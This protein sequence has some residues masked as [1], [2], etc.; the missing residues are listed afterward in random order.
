MSQTSLVK[1]ISENVPSVPDFRPRFPLGSGDRREV[2]LTL[3]IS[4]RYSQTLPCQ[5]ITRKPSVCPQFPQFPGEP[6][7]PA[8]LVGLLKELA[9]VTVPAEGAGPGRG[10]RSCRQYCRS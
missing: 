1:Q 2:S 7:R 3:K 10:W 9:D 4:N 8:A 5:I 6:R